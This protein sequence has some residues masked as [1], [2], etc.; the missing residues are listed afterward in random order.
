MIQTIQN[1]LYWPQGDLLPPLDA[2]HNFKLTGLRCDDHQLAQLE[3]SKYP[4][5]VDL[6]V[7]FKWTFHASCVLNSHMAQFP[8][9]NHIWYSAHKLHA[10]KP[11]SLYRPIT[12]TTYWTELISSPD[13]IPS[14]YLSRTVAELHSQPSFWFSI[15]YS[16]PLRPISP[17]SN[18]SAHELAWV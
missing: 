15:S 7:N 1:W 5:P 9:W 4:K 14:P 18:A 13:D 2:S 17:R 11:I 10:Q 12:C 16:H 6:S 3:V 8:R